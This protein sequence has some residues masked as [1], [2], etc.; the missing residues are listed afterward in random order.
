MPTF[1]WSLS[2][3]AEE[4]IRRAGGRRRYN[5]WRR[6]CALYR[7]VQVFRLL[8]EYGGEHGSITRIARQLGVH[9]ST[10]SRDVSSVLRAETCWAC[11]RRKW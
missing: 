1:D 4:T 10:V 7:Q 8:R 9:P 2:V 3:S 6:D 5:R 11:G